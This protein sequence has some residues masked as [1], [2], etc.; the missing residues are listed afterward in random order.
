MWGWLCV[1]VCVRLWVQAKSNVDKWKFETIY[2]QFTEI[3]VGH[4]K[5]TTARGVDALPKNPPAGRN[6]PQ[7]MKKKNNVEVKLIANEWMNKC[8]QMTANDR[9]EWAWEVE[10][11]GRNE[12]FYEDWHIDNIQY[13]HVIT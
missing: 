3:A 1:C 8:T 5:L 2:T 9:P 13:L 7:K 4:I 6:L 10:V 11:V 12:K